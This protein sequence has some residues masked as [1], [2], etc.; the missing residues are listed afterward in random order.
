MFTPEAAGS[1]PSFLRLSTANEG[2]GLPVCEGRKKEDF[3]TPAGL[4]ANSLGEGDKGGE[5]A[6][7]LKLTLS[8]IWEQGIWSPQSKTY[9]YLKNK[10]SFDVGQL[11]CL[12]PFSTVVYQ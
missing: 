4:S 6:S 2:S 9:S 12:F 11:A 7:I 10:T 3:L 8:E 5:R 1:P